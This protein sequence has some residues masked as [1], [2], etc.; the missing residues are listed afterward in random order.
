MVKSYKKRYVPD[1]PYAMRCGCVY[2]HRLVMEELLGRYLMPTEQVHHK[3]EDKSNND[4]SNLELCPTQKDHSE[5]HAYQDDVLIDMLV[6][7]ADMRGKLPSRRQ[8]DEESQLPHSS[9]YIRHFGSWSE[10]KNLAQRAID[11]TNEE[12]EYYYA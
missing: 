1:H 9:T 2:E 7:Y 12:W 6:A 10:A 11:F 8:C 3:D 5:Q 4:P